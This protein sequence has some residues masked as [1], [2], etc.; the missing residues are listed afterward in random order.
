MIHDTVFTCFLKELGVKFTNSF[1]DKLFSEHPYKYTLFGLSKMLTY[2]GVRNVGIK[3]TNREEIHSLETPFIAHIGNDFVTVKNVSSKD[4]CYYW[5]KKRLTIP[6][7]DFLKIWSGAI[8]VAEADEKSIEPD[9]KQH[10][11][12]EQAISIQKALLLLAGMVLIGIGF[13][14]NQIFQN[15]GLSLLL[16]LN[17]AGVYVGYLLVQK[18]SFSI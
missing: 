17:L 3:V 15:W 12:E 7:K 8:L 1:S 10:K 11:K 2:Y 14:Q 9:Y 16:M 18:Q 5:H 13:Y 4:I 6:I